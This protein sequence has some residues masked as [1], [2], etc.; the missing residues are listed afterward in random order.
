MKMLSFVLVAGK[1]FLLSDLEIAEALVM[2]NGLKLTVDISFLNLIAESDAS[3]VVLRL[4]VHQQSST[5]VI[6]IE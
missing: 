6:S 5:Y 1:F 4:N 2:Q 3:N